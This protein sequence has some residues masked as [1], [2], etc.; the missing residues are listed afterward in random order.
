[1]RSRQRNGQRPIGV[2]PVFVPLFLDPRDW[3]EVLLF[4][5]HLDGATISDV[6]DWAHTADQ[7]ELSVDTSTTSLS[8]A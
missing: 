8:N 2:S 3:L 6:A 7:P 4:A 5:A 1:M